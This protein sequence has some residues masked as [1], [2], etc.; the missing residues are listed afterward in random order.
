MK[1]DLVSLSQTT[2]ARGLRRDVD[3]TDRYGVDYQ[4]RPSRMAHARAPGRLFRALARAARYPWLT[5]A[6]KVGALVTVA[7]LIAFHPG[8]H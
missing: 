5:W 7:L 2:F 8:V 4:I 3:A 6:F 1:R